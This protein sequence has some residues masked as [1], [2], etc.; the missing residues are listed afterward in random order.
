MGTWDFEAERHWVPYFELDEPSFSTFDQYVVSFH[1]VITQFTPASMEVLP[2][3]KPERLFNVLFI[4]AAMT[5]FASF[6][7]GVTAS[8]TRLRHIAGVDLSHFFLLRRFL[9]EHNISRGL[10]LRIC[11]YTDLAQDIHKK[12]IG[13]EQVEYLKLLSGPLNVELHR[14]LFWPH[15]QTHALFSQYDE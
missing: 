2:Q 7:G 6:I 12:H 11:R 4:L 5:A 3:N 8:I 9:H 14:E 1:W 10:T 13:W 15:L